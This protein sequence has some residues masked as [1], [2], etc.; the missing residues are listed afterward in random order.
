MPGVYFSVGGTPQETLEAA[1]RGEAVVP[2]HHS[3]FFRIEPEP[4][5]TA[6]VEAM[7]VAARALL[8]SR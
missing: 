1:E 5:V 6:G 2:S 8:D 4:A 7:V 3:P